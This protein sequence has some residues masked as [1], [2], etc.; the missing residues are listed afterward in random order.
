MCVEKHVAVRRLQRIGA[1]ISD[2]DA[3]PAVMRR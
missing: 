1:S 3:H 2:L